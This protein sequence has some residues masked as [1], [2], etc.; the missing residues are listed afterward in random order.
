MSAVA[1][2]VAA[3]RGL[4]AGGE[5]PKQYQLL[6]GR[7][8][9]AHTLERFL[10]HEDI[11]SVVPVIHEADRALYAAAVQDLTST[12]LASTKL[13][14]PSIGA[15]TRQASVRAG[16][17]TAAATGAE[18][19]LI[20]DAVR[21]F[22]PGDLIGRAVA[23]ARHFGAAV[24]G[25]PVDDTVVEIAGEMVAGIPPRAA[26]KAVQ[27]PQAFRLSLIAECHRRA[28]QDGREDFTDDGSLVRAYGYEVHVFPGDRGNG[29]LT[30]AAD[31]A[32]AERRMAS[33]DALV[34]RVASGFDV[35]AF[36]PGDHVWLGGVRIPYG[37][38]LVG[39]SDAD[40]ALHALTD[41]VLGTLADG[42]IGMHFP[43]SD[44]AWKGA[45]SDLFL[46]FAVAKVRD[47]G[48][49]VDHLD[50][51][52]VCE[53]PKIGPHRDAVRARI[54]AICDLVPEQVS[55]KATTTERLGFTGRGEGISALATA[56]I[57]LPAARPR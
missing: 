14:E 26:L 40:V 23:A 36:G 32:A 53:A 24:P 2:I 5:V 28:Q 18:I 51:T 19:V 43:P 39:H 29:K 42:D 31:I 8:V 22:V 45:S 37:Q 6:G 38:G 54:A 9:I 12:N 57:R 34:T 48:G 10:A 13:R 7:P 1:I 27:T 46:A 41:A 56:T 55:V 35:H 33:A 15:A 44:P 30:S 25:V 11:T 3:G 50:V 16:I 21:P 49:V 4:R 52:I 47:A 17:E 20:H